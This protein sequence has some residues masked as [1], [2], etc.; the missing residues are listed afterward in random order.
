MLKRDGIRALVKE[1]GYGGYLK[2]Q[3]Q[4]L[5]MD[6]RGRVP[7][8][9]DG[10]SQFRESVQL[11]N[12]IT[13]PRKSPREFSIK[14]LWEGLVGPVEETLPGQTAQD[15]VGLVETDNR[16]IEAVSSGAF[17]SA[18]GQ[19][20][21]AEVIEAYEMTDG[22]IGDELV[23]PFNSSLRGERVIGFTGAQG[24]KVVVEGEPY[25]DA[26][27]GEKFVGTRE[28][29]RGRLISVTEE[30]VFFD[31]TGQMLDRAQ[32]IGEAA[33][34]DRERRIV[35]GCIDYDS[36]DAIYA[37]GGTAEQLYAAGN[38]NLRTTAVLADWTDI[39]ETMQ[40]HALN[41]TDDREPDDEGAAQPLTWIPRILLTSLEL[42][43]TA[44]MVVQTGSTALT[45][46]VANPLNLILSTGIRALASPFIDVATG[47][48]Q[49]DDNSDWFLG[50]F[51]KQFRY[52]T[53]WPLQTFRAPAM[54]DQQFERDVLARFKV[55]EYGDVLAVD[56]R[57]VVKCDAA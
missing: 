15:Q 19:L 17:P 20:I 10:K 34:Q 33:R 40:Y 21:A 32:M 44:A 12:G 3:A 42:A 1:H 45:T 31:Q 29:K 53:I 54:N 24:P 4:M 46:T 7:R 6:E 55:R 9:K 56:E 43:G 8:D 50:D 16:Y 11:P 2:L 39:Q 51:Q 27:F 14:A 5:G 48:D 23:R 49:W 47:G 18:V 35:Q 38:N 22:F 25:Q 36:G 13:M 57:W 52:K 37:P 30:A 28:T 26:T 41:V